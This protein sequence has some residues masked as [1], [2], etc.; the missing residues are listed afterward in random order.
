MYESPIEKIFGQI[1]TQ[2]VK[3]DEDNMM[4]QVQQAV[5]YTVN[6]EEL[7]RALQYD[8]QQYEK[9]YADACRIM[10]GW[11][12]ISERLPEVGIDVLIC[13]MEGTIYLSHRSSYGSYFDEWGHKIKGIRAWMPLPEPYKAE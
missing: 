7:I 8:R 1:Q 5:G 3:N 12:P 2:M 6:K 4:V 13:D 11:I 10:T 9:G